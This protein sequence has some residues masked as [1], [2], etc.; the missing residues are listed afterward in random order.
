MF[1]R[2]GEHGRSGQGPRDYYVEQVTVHEDFV[3]GARRLRN[4][5]AVIR[6]ADYVRFDGTQFSHSVRF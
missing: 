1:V 2:L 6:L 3:A 5:I 4:D